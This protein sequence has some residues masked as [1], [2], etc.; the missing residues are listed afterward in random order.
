MQRVTKFVEQRCRVIQTD[1]GRFT[2]PAFDEIIIIG[3]QHIAVFPAE[4][5]LTAIGR[6]PR[7][8][9]FAFTREIIEI[10]KPNNP[11][12][13]LDF[14]GAD[15]GI[16]YGHAAGV[17]GEAHAVKFARRIEHGVDHIVEFEIGFNLGGIEIIFRLA[18][19]LRVETV[20]PRCDGD[21]R[22]LGIGHRLHI[23][24][25]FFYSRDSGRPDLHH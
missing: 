11:V 23:R 24:D 16:K 8:G 7:A 3:G 6:H 4:R 14:K 20:I 9:A 13:A 17:I 21:T 25:F 15:F 19:F 10:E 1:E 5:M 18:D 2:L 22:T 12:A